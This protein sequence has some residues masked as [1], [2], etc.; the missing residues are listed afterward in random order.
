M[1]K[2]AKKTDPVSVRLDPDV[3]AELEA[4]ATADDRS[5][6]AYIARVLTQHVAAVRAKAS[7]GR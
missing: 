3:K 5:L 4:L 2:P 6:S 7:K 1:K